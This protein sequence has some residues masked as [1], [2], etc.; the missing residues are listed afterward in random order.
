MGEM[1]EKEDINLGNRIK[2]QRNLFRVNRKRNPQTLPLN[3]NQ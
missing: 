1:K 3:N 2:V